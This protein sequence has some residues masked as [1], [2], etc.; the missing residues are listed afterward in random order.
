MA[1]PAYFETEERR[2]ALMRQRQRDLAGTE[3]A[4]LEPELAFGT[5]G[6]VAVD[7]AGNLAAATSTGGRTN[8]RYGRIGDS[9][10]I[11]AGTYADAN[12][13]VSAT[14][15]GEYFIRWT[16]ARD[17]CARVEFGGQTIQQAAQGVMDDLGEVGG[18]GALI[19]MDRQGRISLAMNGRGMYR[20][21][22]VEGETART[23][24]YRGSPLEGREPL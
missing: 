14:G 7:A 12:C 21:V 10:I 9:P 23:A 24:V 8:K 4:S 11:G 13:A 2:S 16:V 22:L 19:A 15:H 20:G 5:V 6:A 1:D 17:V 18:D 3:Q